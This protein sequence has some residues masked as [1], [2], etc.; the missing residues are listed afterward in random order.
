LRYSVCT[1][2]EVWGKYNSLHFESKNAEFAPEQ[3]SEITG[4]DINPNP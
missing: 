3:I 2:S 1:E 4:I